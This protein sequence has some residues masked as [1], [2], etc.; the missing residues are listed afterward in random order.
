MN[1]AKKILTREKYKQIK[2]MDHSQMQIFITE[3]YKS[4]YAD[5][6]ADS[7]SKAVDLEAL[8]EAIST[9]KGVGNVVYKN[10]MEKVEALFRN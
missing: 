4:G 5:G 2:K 9:S 7:E 6:K 8:K 10:I 1:R 3:I